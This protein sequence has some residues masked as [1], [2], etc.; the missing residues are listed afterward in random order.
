MYFTN[1]PYICISDTIFLEAGFWDT[2][3]IVQDNYCS[4][5]KFNIAGCFRWSSHFTNKFDICISD[6]NLLQAGLE[7]RWW[8]HACPAPGGQAGRPPGEIFGHIFGFIFLV[9]FN[10]W[11]CIWSYIWAKLGVLHVKYLLIYLV[12][13]L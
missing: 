11:Y 9:H 13:Y 6:P 3:I 12:L 7:R 1:K 8:G 5:H 2:N 10:I 4:Y